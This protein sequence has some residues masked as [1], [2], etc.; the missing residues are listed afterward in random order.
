MLVCFESTCGLVDVL[1]PG[2]REVIVED[3]CHLL[4]AQLMVL[5]RESFADSCV[6]AWLYHRAWLRQ[7]QVIEWLLEY[8]VDCIIK[9]QHP[10]E[11]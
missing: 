11:L 8:S 7:Q 10:H 1:E 2:L 6:D 4:N 5:H 3:F 9:T